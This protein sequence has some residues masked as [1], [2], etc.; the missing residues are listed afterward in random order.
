MPKRVHNRRLKPEGWKKAK[1]VLWT[2]RA[3]AA[4]RGTPSAQE[5]EEVRYP[6]KKP[7]RYL[8][9]FERDDWDD[10]DDDGTDSFGVAR[11]G[12]K[13][14][15]RKRRTSKKKKSKTTRRKA[16]KRASRKRRRTR[17]R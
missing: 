1:D 14:R 6:F 2:E 11:G 9:V 4:R 10:D 16:S 12:G 8:S 7:T 13:R 3:R 15:R 17:R 5:G